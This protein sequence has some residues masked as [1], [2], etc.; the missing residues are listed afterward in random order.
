MG[1][2]RAGFEVVCANDIDPEMAWHYQKNLTPPHYVLAPIKQFVSMLP[3]AMTRDIDLL[4]GSPPCSTF[5]MSGLREK[6]WGKKKHFREGQSAQVLDD[7]FFDFL[8]VAEALRP[9]AIVAEN[10]KGLVTGNAK[11]YV[12]LIFERLR[13]IGYVPQVF[14]VNA[15]RCGVP[16]TRERVFFCALRDDVRK[17]SLVLAPS[18]PVVSAREA[19]ADI[20][21]TDEEIRDTRPMPTDLRWYAR[22]LP[23]ETYTSAVER[24]GLKSKLW[25]HRR[26][27]GDRPA[28]TLTA[29][30]DTFKHWSECRTLT[31][32]EWFRLGSFPDDYAAK[33]PDIAR[34]MVGMSVPPKM[35]EVVAAAVRDQWLA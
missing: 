12:R 32:R 24:S 23:G 9:R 31:A 17:S 14:L 10:V 7:L 1:Y 22:T 34:Y 3:V 15:A 4:D 33:N 8:E 19:C 6:A 25:S 21:L 5:S 18:V 13:R 26:L 30:H 29:A 16:Q 28:F 2:K 20:V 11:G 35:T 27:H